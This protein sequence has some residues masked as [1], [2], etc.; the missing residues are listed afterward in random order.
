VSLHSAHRHT[1]DGHTHTQTD[2]HTHTHTHLTRRFTIHKHTQQRRSTISHLWQSL[3]PRFPIHPY[4]YYCLNQSS[5]DTHNRTSRATEPRRHHTRMHQLRTCQTCPTLVPSPIDTGITRPAPFLLHDPPPVLTLHSHI[6]QAAPP[7]PHARPRARSPMPPTPEP[8]PP[9]AIPMSVPLL[10]CWGGGRQG[11][12]RG[13]G[14]CYARSVQVMI[15]R[16]RRQGA[17]STSRRRHS[18]AVAASPP[19]SHAARGCDA[20]GCAGAP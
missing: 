4:Y 5:F 12:G 19:P 18:C 8:A 7:L 13:R 11:G 16:D 15:W 3:V 6:N 14:L 20:R 9:P 1:R 2:T 17:Q 10:C